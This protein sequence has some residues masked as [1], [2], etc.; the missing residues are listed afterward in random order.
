ME[1]Y[2][3]LVEA[4]PDRNNP[5]RQE[6]GGAYINCWVKATTKEDAVT[7]TKA[8]IAAENWT[9][10]KILDVF[11]AQKQLYA[12]E[13]DSAVCYD[14]ACENGISAIFYTWSIDPD[15]NT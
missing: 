7:R 4:V 3:L 14:E 2:Y 6:F 1:I 11:I 10:V 15:N 8:Y 5:E 13:P 9:F 12:D